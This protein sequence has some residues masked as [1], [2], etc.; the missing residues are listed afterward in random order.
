MMIDIKMWLEVAG[1]VFDEGASFRLNNGKVALVGCTRGQ[2]CVI[3][4]AEYG[5]EPGAAS[6][7]QVKEVLVLMRDRMVG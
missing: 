7:T 6:R 5:S 2:Q 4:L 3:D 1:E